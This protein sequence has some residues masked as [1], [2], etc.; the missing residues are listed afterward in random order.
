MNRCNFPY[1]YMHLF[2]LVKKGIIRIIFLNH[3]NCYF[4]ED[5]HLYENNYLPITGFDTTKI[6]FRVRFCSSDSNY[7]EFA[8][9]IS[10]VNNILQ[11][12]Q[13]GRKQMFYLMTHST[14]F[15]LR[16]YGI[17][18]MV[19]DHSDSEKGNLLLPHWL[20]FLINSKGSFICTIPH[21]IAHTT[22]LVTPVMEH[23]LERE[24]AQWVHPMKDRSDDPS[25]HERTPLPRSYISLKKN[26]KKNP[27]E[28]T[29]N[30]NI[31][32]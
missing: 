1:L 4:H 8:N 24:I 23:W 2:V 22:A 32:I 14:H 15:I 16:F 30:N 5:C 17:G 11:P 21:R 13:F 19:K 3:C 29:C 27:F 20:L 25:H 9:N 7:D 6:G 10:F 18:H 26:K 28:L 12:F 31:K